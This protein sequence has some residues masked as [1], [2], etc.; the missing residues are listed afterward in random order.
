MKKLVASLFAALGIGTT[1][2]N[3]QPLYEASASFDSDIVEPFLE[4]LNK[5][6]DLGLDV[7]NL[8]EFTESVPHDEEYTKELEVTYRGK[9]TKLEFHVFKDAP[10]APDLYFF[11][12]SE[13]LATE[14]TSLFEVFFEERSM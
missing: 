9:V 11:T 10:Y 2:V 12:P 14:I 6:K 4:R 7:N 5:E 1:A 8:V 13:E 3:S